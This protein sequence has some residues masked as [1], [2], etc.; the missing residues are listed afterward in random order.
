M[1]QVMKYGIG[2]LNVVTID[3]LN[4]SGRRPLQSTS[5][6]ESFLGTLWCTTAASGARNH[7]DK[8]ITRNRTIFEARIIN[9]L[10]SYP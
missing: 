3:R 7:L 4:V 10:L 8:G 6:K 9:V 1:S 2:T 5:W